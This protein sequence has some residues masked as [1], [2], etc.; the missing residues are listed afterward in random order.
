MNRIKHA[1]LMIAIVMVA[2]PLLAD[3]GRRRTATSP[4][5]PTKPVYTAGQAEA[6]VSGDTIGYIRPGLKIKVNSITIGNDRIPVADLT[7]TDD[8]DQ[9]LDRT[10]KVTPGTVSVSL[11][12][13]WYNPATRQY[14]AYTTRSVTNPANSPKPG[15]TGIQAGA[16]S[17][18]TWTDRDI[19]HATYKFKTVLPSG[20]DTTKPHTL[21]I[22]ASRNLTSVVGI[23]TNVQKSYF[24]NVEYR[25]EERRVGKECRSRWAPYH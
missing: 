15:A 14:T 10:G 20:S 5:T 6:Y 12:L 23:P 9:P 19:G 4:A 13:S 17:G 8:L 18:G 16:D 24:A 1:A 22:D 11:I 25:S 3:G 7:I 21:G 2:L